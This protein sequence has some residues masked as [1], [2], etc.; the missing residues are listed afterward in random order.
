MAAAVIPFLAAPI[1]G[2][3]YLP[4]DYALLAAF[5]ALVNV[6]A[7]IATLHYQHGIVI[8]KT[9]QRAHQLA[10]VAL[11]ATAAFAMFTIPVAVA[12]YLIDPFAD[13]FR[14]YGLW[15][16]ALPFS[17]LVVGT[18]LTAM[19]IAN[20]DQAYKILSVMQFT[21][22][23]ASALASI[24]F[25]LLSLRSDGLMLAAMLSQAITLGFSV[26]ILHRRNVLRAGI[27]KRKLMRLSARHRGYPL[28][29]MPASFLQSV[30]AQLPILALTSM[31]AATT[32]GSFSRAQQLLILPVSM[33]S[34]AVARV[35]IQ[36]AAEEYNKTGSCR[37]LYIRTVPIISFVA[38]PFFLTFTLLGET[39]FTVYLGENWREAGQIA[40]ILCPVLVFQMFVSSL[41]SS[42]LYTGNQ[43][44]SLHLHAFGLALALIGCL[45][46]QILHADALQVLQGWALA[47]SALGIIQIYIGWKLA[48]QTTRKAK[49]GIHGAIS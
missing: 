33:F 30:G 34:G 44:L 12:L 10:L 29:T 8:E 5:G 36:R 22:S 26:A 21:A 37:A 16:A 42:I 38:I 13:A 24:A 6:A 18:S 9:T 43:H 27:S 35:Y 11:A 46:P 28:F 15:F 17:T 41:G 20:R 40:Q 39:I 7:S 14:G 32:L 49:G 1:L 3:I 23:A 48:K 19:A 47:L 45:V 25:G 31:G 4:E 2:R